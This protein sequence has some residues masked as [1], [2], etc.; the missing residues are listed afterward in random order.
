MAALEGV[1]TQGR[2]QRIRQALSPAEWRRA[3]LMFASILLL[4]VVASS[5]RQ[6]L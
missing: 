1:A 6:Q 2:I 5:W 4:H 3:Q